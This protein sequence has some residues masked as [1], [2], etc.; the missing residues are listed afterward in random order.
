MNAQSPGYNAASPIYQP[1]NS[2]GSGVTSMPRPG[3]SPQYSPGSIVSPRVPN[4]GGG[5]PYSPTYN[6]VQGISAN[7][8]GK[9]PAYSPASNLSRMAAPSPLHHSPAYSPGSLLGQQKSA[10]AGGSSAYEKMMGTS[11]AQDRSPQHYPGHSP[12]AY[13]PI[14][15]VYQGSPNKPYDVGGHS[16]STPAYNPGKGNQKK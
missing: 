6:P 2:V 1:A 5:K 3:Q 10:I 11:P 4:Q 15:P 16:P 8:G 12:G 13:K 7:M 14:S 9:S